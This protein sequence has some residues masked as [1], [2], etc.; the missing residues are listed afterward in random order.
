MSDLFFLWGFY[1]NNVIPKK[2]FDY[3]YSWHSMNQQKYIRILNKSSIDELVNEY[4]KKELKDNW[5]KLKPIQQCDVARYFLMYYFGGNYSDMDVQCNLSLNSLPKGNIILGTE[6]II[7]KEFAEKVG[8]NNP[9]RKGYA[10]DCIRVANYWFYTKTK[11]HPFWQ[12]VLKMAL[13]RCIENNAI[14]Q[15]DVLYTS[16]P[17]VITTVYHRDKCKYD[18]IVLLDYGFM[19]NTINHTQ[20][21]SWRSDFKK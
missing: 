5:S 16:G 18:D 1:T 3:V 9:I 8:K 21:G 7:S 20:T 4:G 15:Y 13:K 12:S 14:T 6:I 19:K 10:E 17:D 2:L 11:K